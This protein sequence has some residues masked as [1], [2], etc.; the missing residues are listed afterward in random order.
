[1]LPAD[2]DVA[3]VDLKEVGAFAAHLLAKDDFS[4]H[5][6]AKYII[7]GPE[8]ITGN[9]LVNLIEKHAGV[10][11]ESVQ[12]EDLSIYDG[13]ASMGYSESAIRSIR[14]A[15]TA[16]W[17]GQTGLRATPTSKKVLETAPPRVTPAAALESFLKVS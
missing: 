15:P 3:P 5:N 2:K 16:M 10:R 4:P 14:F 13:L 11:P 9:R 6:H 7:N 17:Q 1:M 12:F 8:D